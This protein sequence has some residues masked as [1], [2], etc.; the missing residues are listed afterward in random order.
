[1]KIKLSAILLTITLACVSLQARDNNIFYPPTEVFTKDL[2]RADG[3]NWAIQASEEGMVYTGNNRGLL[4]YD[5]TGGNSF[6]IPEH[7]PFAPFSW[8]KVESM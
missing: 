2:Y 4:V 7:I 6:N 1:M 3:K 5:G 8:R